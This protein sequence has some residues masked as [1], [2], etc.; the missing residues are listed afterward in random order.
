MGGKSK[1][2]YPGRSIEI[3]RE[4]TALKS[5]GRLP[6]IPQLCASLLRTLH[7]LS[8]FQYRLYEQ[9]LFRFPAAVTALTGPNGSGKTAVLDAAYY[10]CY[11]KSYFT[12]QQQALARWGSPGFKI[13]GELADPLFPERMHTVSCRWED[14]KKEIAVDGAAYPKPSDHIGRWAAVMIAP[15]DSELLLGSAEGRRRWADSILA[16]TD[17]QYLDHLTQYNRLLQQRNAWLKAQ[18]FGPQRAD[19]ELESY[20][21]RMAESG[22]YL[23][24]R[25]KAFSADFVPLLRAMYA[26]L[27]AGAE[28]VDLAYESDL[29]EKSAGEWLAET[30]PADLRAQRTGRGVHKD[31]WIFQIHEK[32][33]RLYASQG[34]RK[35]LL[36]ALKLAQYRYLQQRFGFAPLLLLDDVFEKLDQRRIEALLGIIGE[37]QFGQVLLTDTHSERIKEAFGAA[38]DLSFIATGEKN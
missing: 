36:F 8:L 38:A 23:Y 33:V 20:N 4:S 34:Q 7:Q 1:A 35:S 29:H 15:D 12:A 25:R 14:G 19:A 31:D 37:P 9:E 17:R 11:T 30:L 3:T 2:E 5:A 21:H 22:T 27:S 18:A 10:L 13:V 6:K 16:Q 28:A 26:R 24:E 32:P